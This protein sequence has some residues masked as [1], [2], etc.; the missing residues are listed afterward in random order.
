MAGKFSRLFEPVSIGKVEIKNRIAM[1]PM[2]LAGLVNPD[3]SLGPRAMDYYVERA[4]GGVG[5]IITGLFKVENEVEPFQG[6]F[7]QMSRQALA[8]FVEGKADLVAIGKGFLADAFWARK[9]E[10]GKA[11]RIRPCIGCHDG[12]MGRISKTKP[13]SCAV[14]PATGRERSYRLE[15]AEKPKKV[16]IVGG[17]PA[18]LEAARVAALRGHRVTLWER[19]SS[20]GGHLREASVPEFKKDLARYLDWAK[21]EVAGLD[22]EVRTG[23]EVDADRIRAENPE[24]TII[25]TGSKP[26]IPKVPG[27]G[28]GKA[29]TAVDLLGGKEMPGKEILVLGGGLIGCETAL[30]LAQQGKKV[31]I[32]EILPDL[33]TG[34]SLLEISP[35][36][37]VLT[38]KDTSTRK[39][40]ADTIVLAVGLAP[41]QNLYRSLQGQI[42][43][44]FLI[45]D[46][47]SAQNIMNSVWDAY[48][49]ARMI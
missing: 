18:G 32:V 42:P 44:L 4:R 30:W 12:C 11:E 45:G 5:L 33:L 38:G 40:P 35:E 39:L 10:E 24:V 48:E 16:V 6:V 41:E 2:G 36:G 43:N 8:P 26:V 27:L 28:K 31:T 22:L 47:R 23:I 21:R 29:V 37:A 25:A 17:G 3:G 1:A 13:L 14:N 49:V 46:S 34:T 9:A 19:E 15:R 20:L 7:S